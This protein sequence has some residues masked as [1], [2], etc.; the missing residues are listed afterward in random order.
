MTPEGEDVYLKK[1]YVQGLQR[2]VEGVLDRR[3]K[4]FVLRQPPSHSG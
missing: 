3:G 4:G 1:S 2:I